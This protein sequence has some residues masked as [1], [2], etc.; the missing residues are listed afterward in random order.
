[1]NGLNSIRL[2]VKI[3]TRS[4]V[5]CDGPKKLLYFHKSSYN[6]YNQVERRYVCYA[7]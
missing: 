2:D 4:S 5:F 6:S 7:N 3:N 1:M